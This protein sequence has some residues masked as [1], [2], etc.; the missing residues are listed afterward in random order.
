MSDH[1]STNFGWNFKSFIGGR[2]YGQNLDSADF[3]PPRPKNWPEISNTAKFLRFFQV[4]SITPPLIL[5][6]FYCGRKKS[7][8][9]HD[10]GTCVF[11]MTT[12]FCGHGI[13]VE[14]LRKKVLSEAPKKCIFW[15]N[16]TNFF[17]NSIKFFFIHDN[18]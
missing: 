6:D 7:Y 9:L 5:D 4:F 13:E 17:K 18:H 12:N 10:L 11:R 2:E 16:N 8:C 15:K 1:D 14:I 3:R